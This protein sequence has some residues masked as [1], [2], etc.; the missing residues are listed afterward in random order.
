MIHQLLR[1]GRHRKGDQGDQ[2][3][4]D[5]VIHERTTGVTFTNAFRVMI[6]RGINDKGLA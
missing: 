4:G 3:V 2:G 6:H 5:L 1:Q